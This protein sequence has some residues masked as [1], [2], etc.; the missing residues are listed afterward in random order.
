MQNQISEKIDMVYLWCD[1]N[2]KDFRN[3]RKFYLKTENQKLDE[4]VIGEKRFF[5]NEELRY[6]LRSLEKMH[7]G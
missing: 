6:S 5:D 1:G 7:H 2:E 4:E 3:R